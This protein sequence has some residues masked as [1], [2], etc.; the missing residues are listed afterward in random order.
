MVAM[1]TASLATK[2]AK[3]NENGN[4]FSEVSFN[5]WIYLIQVASGEGVFLYCGQ[6]PKFA[7]FTLTHTHIHTHTNRHSHKHIYTHSLTGKGH[8]QI[9]WHKPPASQPAYVSWSDNKNSHTVA[10]TDAQLI[11]PAGQ[12]FSVDIQRQG[13]NRS[14]P[15]NRG[16]FVSNVI[17]FL[18]EKFE[19]FR[20]VIIVAKKLPFNFTYSSSLSTVHLGSKNTFDFNCYCKIFTTKLSI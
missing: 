3:I 11:W 17:A 12:I 13:R 9:S 15:K 6:N 10:T 8:Y 20:V 4:N 14:H 7:A 5:K 19:Y 18:A 1:V 2:I 16:A